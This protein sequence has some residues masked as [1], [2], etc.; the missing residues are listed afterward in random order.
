LPKLWILTPTT[1]QSIVQGFGG[2][3]KSDW[4]QGVYVC[5]EFLRM[6]IVVIH[7]LP[8]DSDTLLLRLFGRGRVQSQAILEVEALPRDHPCKLILLEQLYNLQQNLSLQTEIDQESQE[9]IMRLLPLYQQDRALAL[10]EGLREGEIKLLIRQLKQ[11]FGEL[12]PDLPEQI[13]ALPTEKLE[14][15]AEALFDFQ[16]SQDLFN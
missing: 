16:S 7:Q 2:E 11:R 8:V 13:R 14:I 10:Q 3:L 5:P 15:L 9:L 12:S 6:A 4:S 1:S